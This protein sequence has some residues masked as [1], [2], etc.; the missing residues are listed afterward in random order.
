MKKNIIFIVVLSLFYSNFIWALAP[1]TKLDNVKF[2]KLMTCFFEVIKDLKSRF[3]DKQDLP[4]V[5]LY[6]LRD[7]L[8]DAIG[9]EHL[10]DN[11]ELAL[12]SEKKLIYLY[13]EN[14]TGGLGV[15]YRI[16]RRGDDQLKAEDDN[17]LYTEELGGLTV[18]VYRRTEKWNRKI[19]KLRQ[20]TSNKLSPEE[21]KLIVEIVSASNSDLAKS[22]LAKLFS[23]TERQSLGV[24]PESY[25]HGFT[26]DVSEVV[27]GAV[28]KIDA[29]IADFTPEQKKGT[30]TG[31]SDE[32]VARKISLE[33]QYFDSMVS[34]RAIP[35]Y[36]KR[37]D[38]AEARGDVER[39][40]MYEGFCM[41][42]DDLLA[43]IA[44]GDFFGIE[45]ESQILVQ[46]RTAKSLLIEKFEEIE[47]VRATVTNE[48]S[49]AT[50]VELQFLIMELIEHIRSKINFPKNSTK[51]AK[52]HLI[53]NE[54]ARFERVL[55]SAK[56]EFAGNNG[57]LSKLVDLLNAQVPELISKHH[58]KAGRAIF[59][60]VEKLEL[61]GDDTILM[62]KIVDYMIENLESGL[63][64]ENI[65][66]NGNV[67]VV[68]RDVLHPVQ[69]EQ[70]Q[71]KLG[72]RAKIK[73]VICDQGSPLS[74]FSTFLA[75]EGIVVLTGMKDDKGNGFFD[76]IN[77]GET[78]GVY[79]FN[80]KV[81]KNLNQ[82]TS[83]QLDRVALEEYVFYDYVRRHAND[84]A[85]TLDGLDLDVFG[86]AD[87]AHQIQNVV[88][89]GGGGVGLV[90]SEYLYNR[91]NLPKAGELT[92]TFRNL[93]LSANG[94]NKIVIRLLDKQDDKEM[95]CLPFSEKNGFDYYRDEQVVN[96]IC[97]KYVVKSELKS[98]L[99]AFLD[100]KNI[101]VMFPQIS[102]PEDVDYALQLLEE[103]KREIV[104][105]KE[106]EKS[107]L[108]EMKIGFMV[109]TP[110][111]VDNIEYL[112]RHCDFVSIGTNDLT[113]STFGVR[114]DD[115]NAAA[116]FVKLRPEILGKIYT[117]LQAARKINK[118]LPAGQ[119]KEVSV[120]GDIARHRK[121]LA[122]VLA[123]SDS[124]IQLSASMPA[125]FI[126]QA[127]E[128]IRVLDPQE[129]RAIF[130]ELM[131]GSSGTVKDIDGLSQALIERAIAKIKIGSD[132]K[133]LF[134]H[135]A[136][137]LFCKKIYESLPQSYNY[138]YQYSKEDRLISILKK[139]LE[140]PSLL[141]LL[142]NDGVITIGE[143]QVIQIISSLVEK[144]SEI[145][146]YGATR[147]ELEQIVAILAAD[148]LTSM[149]KGDVLNTNWYEQK[150]IPVVY[151]KRPLTNG[152]IVQKFSD[153]FGDM[154]LSGDKIDFYQLSPG[155]R[156]WLDMIN[157]HPGMAKNLKFGFVVEDLDE[158]KIKIFTELVEKHTG[159]NKAQLYFGENLAEIKGRSGIENLVYLGNFSDDERRQ[160]RDERIKFIQKNG[161]GLPIEMNLSLYLLDLKTE[162][163]YKQD[164]TLH[165]D[166]LAIFA[167]FV[168]NLKRQNL[169]TESEVTQI[170]AYV[171]KDGFI[172]LPKIAKV[173]ELI[174]KIE[175]ER[176]IIAISA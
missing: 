76:K 114:R 23:N 145:S 169:I 121:F 113:K 31:S 154:K 159:L 100:H 37:M 40:K 128:L 139:T 34:K 108:D 82:S 81:V 104:E 147:E 57:N 17:P 166:V 93:A 116:Y 174:E 67:V 149:N 20:R 163:V 140:S 38:E 132:Y 144:A 110:A 170:L 98:I 92:S 80:G 50:L 8:R 61:A 129:C 106:I 176:V 151:Y 142:K 89:L 35:F 85:K 22:V 19:G 7:S 126:P 66:V 68:C 39:R 55:S 131:G 88:T 156:E 1:D 79:G 175:L 160:L 24:V 120:C 12:D 47:Q 5:R 2:C 46:G 56:E 26:N 25:F 146:G 105:E 13:S 3:H 51:E 69:I 72:A 71:E 33:R 138:A 52:D 124:E 97:G 133:E 118:D 90:R 48:K 141:A 32:E 153:I 6:E 45:K 60:V 27:A 54:I 107:V 137:R 15:L 78:V 53:A 103:V 16:Y 4:L 64:G 122:F 101:Q 11:L 73:A 173:G 171:K 36:K 86:N 168:D 161:S 49:M 42:L 29:T 148:I 165:S 172:K 150:Q 111:A 75:Q 83:E 152:M 134:N 117:V 91:P 70:L 30:I 162:Q 10:E 94:T 130:Q 127:K 95:K 21:K 62:K 143:L 58:F 84:K 63:F 167:A 9:N 74:H 109:E 14:P 123:V 157:G 112:L 102:T 155:F 96:G 136:L 59:E 119:K 44:G 115:P 77:D 125:R 43:N 87:R 164:G 158:S 18:E 135:N 28:L 41:V 99:L 65:A